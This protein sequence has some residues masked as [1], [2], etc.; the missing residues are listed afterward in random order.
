MCCDLFLMTF[1][2]LRPALY[3]K[4]T[5]A[6]V[7]SREFCEVFSKVFKNTYF[8]EYLRTVASESASEYYVYIFLSEFRS[9]EEEEEYEN[10]LRITSYLYL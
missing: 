3:R 7:L 6:K 8:V 9:E 5:P 10:Y 1:Q 2:V 4:L